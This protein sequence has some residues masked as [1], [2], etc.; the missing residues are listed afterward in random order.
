M[1]KIFHDPKKCELRPD[2][3]HS[4][5][6]RCRGWVLKVGAIKLC[7]RHRAIVRAIEK[8]A[9]REKARH[10]VHRGKKAAA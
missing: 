4:G 2:N 8:D 5:K 9:N 7:A 6:K 10:P 1:T 3:D